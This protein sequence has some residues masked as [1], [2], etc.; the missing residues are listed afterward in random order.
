MLML[1]MLT[2]FEALTYNINMIYFAVWAAAVVVDF[3]PYVQQKIKY[4]INKFALLWGEAQL[5]LPY[6][7]LYLEKK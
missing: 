3:F 6:V 1:S 2:L 4:E 7:C 5:C